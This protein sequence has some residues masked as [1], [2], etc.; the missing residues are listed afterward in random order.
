MVDPRTS[1]DI[2]ILRAL[3][4]Y[5]VEGEFISFLNSPSYLQTCEFLI[6]CVNYLCSHLCLAKVS[7]FDLSR[8]PSV[9]EDKLD[10]TPSA[11]DH[12]YQIAPSLAIVFDLRF[13][14]LIKYM[15]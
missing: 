10:Y 6:S 4:L 8:D 12:V 11:S 3:M 7:P 15:V 1:I 13:G 2:N 9:H 14:Y 5:T